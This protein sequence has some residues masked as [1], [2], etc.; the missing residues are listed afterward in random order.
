MSQFVS[1]RFNLLA[2]YVLNGDCCRTFPRSV[3]MRFLF[4]R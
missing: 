2:S 3:M 4:H 1:D